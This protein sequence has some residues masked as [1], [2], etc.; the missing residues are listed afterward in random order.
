MKKALIVIVALLVSQLGFA[1]EPPRPFEIEALKA[2]GGFEARQE[3]AKKLGNH[4]MKIRAPGMESAGGPSTLPSIGNPKIFVLL[5]EFP[6]YS[7]TIEASTIQDMLFGAGN[8]GYYPYESLRSF[9]E[10]SSYGKLHIEGDVY[11]WYKAQNVRDTYTNDAEGL[12]EEALAYYH[13]QGM[14]FD[15]YDN[16][17]NGQVEYFAVFWTGP[18]TGWANFW[19]GWQGYFSDGEYT[20]DGKSLGDFSWQ[21]E[22]DNPG[23][24]IHETGH[25]LGIPDYYDYDDSVGPRGGVGGLD[26][27][28]GVWG[29]HN[30][31]SKW[32][33]GWLTPQVVTSAAELTLTPL[34]TTPSA[35]VMAKDFNGAGWEGEY[36]LIQNR[37]SAANDSDLPGNGFMIHHVDARVGC[38]GSTLYNNSYTE[39]KLLRL[40]EADGLEEI[41]KGKWGDAEDFYNASTNDSFTPVSFPCSDF[42]DGT[43]SLVGVT[44]IPEAGESM[45]ASFSLNGLSELSSPNIV[46]PAGEAVDTG[47][48]PTVRWTDVPGAA[49]YEMEIHEGVNTVYKSGTIAAGSTSHAVPAGKLISGHSYSLW[50]KAKGDGASTGSSGFSKRNFSTACGEEPFWITRTFFDPPCDTY[51]GAFAYHPPSGVFVRFGGNISDHT[52]EYDGDKW[53]EHATYPA[54]PD[55]YY[56]AMAYDPV[57]QKILL[58]GGWDDP[59]QDVFG[60]TWLYDPSNHTWQEMNPASR[61]PADWAYRAVTDTKRK[62][63]VIHAPGETWEWNGSDW[64]RTASSGPGYYY[65]NLAYDRNSSKVV[66]F[67]GYNDSSGVCRNETWSYDGAA[68]T[69]L[70]ASNPPDRRCDAIMT[71]DARLG[72]IILFGGSNEYWDIFNDLWS[73]DGS[74][75]EEVPYCGKGPD[76]YYMTLGA[77]DERRGRLVAAKASGETS[78]YEL[79]GLG[80]ECSPVLDPSSQDFAKAGG[81]G[82]FALSIGAACAWSASSDTEWITITSA[83]S[84]TGPATISFSVAANA[85]A[86]RSG[87]ISVSGAIFAVTQETGIVQ[88]QVSSVTKLASPFRLKIQGANFQNGIKVSFG[89]GAGKTEWTNFVLKNSSTIVLKGGTALKSYFPKGTAVKITLENPDGGETETTYTR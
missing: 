14:R 38:D 57:N 27:M 16:D 47:T 20:I 17:G 21:W 42:Y 48:T 49:G 64:S 59:A 34:S 68:W 71:F 29:D 12:I 8:Q 66:Y 72:K 62:V 11:G 52:F 80:G 4:I 18:D 24:I 74:A 39:H 6:D 77:Y 69:K 89:E 19:W 32:V 35:V 43:A 81:T 55:R 3:F 75:W 78:A 45:T 76:G 37:Y 83:A 5:I 58:F 30:A 23:T 7:H 40:M 54:P 56:A 44:A 84:G 61:P 9:Y 53:T 31:Y 15:K 87:N 2:S 70:A 51:Y 22:E 28:D 13:S 88:P 41:E 25:A 60:D 10:R 26:I 33:L 86:A 67:G 1:L 36:F 63:V 79:V 65:G 46:S 82:S 50:L 85:G 73:F